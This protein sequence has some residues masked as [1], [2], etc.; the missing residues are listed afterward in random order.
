MKITSYNP[1]SPEGSRR[2]NMSTE[3]LRILGTRLH[4]VRS[5]KE[6]ARVVLS[7]MEWQQKTAGTVISMADQNTAPTD[8]G[9]R[10][11]N[12]VQR[13]AQLNAVNRAFSMDAHRRLT[14]GEVQERGTASVTPID[15]YAAHVA[16]APVAEV[17]PVVEAVVAEMPQDTTPEAPAP[18]INLDAHRNSDQ[19]TFEI[20]DGIKDPAQRQ[21]YVDSRQRA[22]SSATPATQTSNELY[23]RLAS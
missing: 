5:A 7:A 17:A 18:V 15:H 6:N 14:N 12:S 4:V 2:V 13:N 19:P 1:K 9:N 23:E 21:M 3:V 11:E 22:E 16:P 20:P 10:T 8:A